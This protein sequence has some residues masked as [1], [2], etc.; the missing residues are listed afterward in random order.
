MTYKKVNCSKCGKE[1]EIP[2]KRYNYKLKINENFFCSVECSRKRKCVEA[3]CATCGKKILTTEKIIS[4]SKS[5]RVYCSK[6]CATIMNNHDKVGIKH[7]N[8]RTGMSTY[9]K[10]AFSNYT[11]ECAVCKWHEDE[12]VLQ[13]HHID[14]NRNNNDISNLIILCPTCHFKLTIGKYKLSD[15]KLTICLK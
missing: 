13:V 14:N 3:S 12:D 2:L 4:K 15:D 6:H 5:G 7:P 11:H 9:R 8:F 10:L 1:F